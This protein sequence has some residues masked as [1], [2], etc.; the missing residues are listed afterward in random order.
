M[1]NKNETLQSESH[2]EDKY[3]KMRKFIIKQDPETPSEVVDNMINFQKEIDKHIAHFG[4]I[5][6]RNIKK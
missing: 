1:G 6:S 2:N 5:N 3:Q 4:F